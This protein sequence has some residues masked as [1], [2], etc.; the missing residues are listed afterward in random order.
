MWLSRF[1]SWP[2]SYFRPRP[3]RELIFQNESVNTQAD[4]GSVKPPRTGPLVAVVLAAGQG[5]RMRSRHHKVLHELAGKPLIQRVLDL[6]DGAGAT[7]VVVVL[8]HQADQVRKALPESVETVVQ[9][10]QLGTGHAVQVAAERLKG[11]GAERLLV[12][13]GDAALVRPESLRRLIATDIGPAAPIA[14]LT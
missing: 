11:Y 13:Y 8:G 7:N 5:T 10:P 6:L 14:L 4:G 2:G 3:D 12:H 9:E 1:E